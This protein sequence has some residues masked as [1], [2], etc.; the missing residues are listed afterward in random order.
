MTSK[1]PCHPL[2]D[3]R[4]VSRDRDMDHSFHV[5]RSSQPLLDH[6][7]GQ[8]GTPRSS[9]LRQLEDVPTKLP[10]KLL[11]G[12]GLE[13]DLTRGV[14]LGRVRDAIFQRRVRAIQSHVGLKMFP[15]ED[16][17]NSN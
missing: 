6:N 17:L 12:Y 10:V 9:S 16:F 5:H 11:A 8:W 4:G 3:Q 2:D 7:L 13:G 15:R 1:A 14:T